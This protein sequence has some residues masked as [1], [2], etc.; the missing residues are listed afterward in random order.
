MTIWKTRVVRFA[1]SLTVAAGVIIGL[2][3]LGGALGS[4]HQTSLQLPK[5]SP[6]ATP[7]IDPLTAAHLRLARVSTT[8]AHVPGGSAL[9][10]AYTAAENLAGSMHQAFESA[11]DFGDVYNG[12]ELEC[13]CWVFVMVDVRKPLCPAAQVVAVFLYLVDA[14]SGAIVKE[15][16]E[17]VVAGTTFGNCASSA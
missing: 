8:Q 17:P 15:L 6:H 2:Y 12:A 7:N 3:I 4:R 5:T 9:G 1:A 14:G 13:R 10:T 16:T 11:A